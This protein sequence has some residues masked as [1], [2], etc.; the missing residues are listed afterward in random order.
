MC[1]CVCVLPLGRF[2]VEFGIAMGVIKELLFSY[3][4]Y[5][6]L[7]NVNPHSGGLVFEVG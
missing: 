7:V 1:V 5:Y 4:Q 3:F 2:F 6:F